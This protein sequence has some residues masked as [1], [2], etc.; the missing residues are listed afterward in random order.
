MIASE[1]I[2]SFVEL[3]DMKNIR[4]HAPTSAIFL[5]GGQTDIKA[6]KPVSLRDAF[7]RINHGVPFSKFEYILA[8]DVNIFS[9]GS[10]YKDFLRLEA[11]IAQISELIMLFSESFGSAAELGAF[12]M[13]DE[14]AMRLMVVID[15]Y[16]YGRDSFIKHGPLLAL[17][18]DYGE[19]SV[20]VL[21]RNGL[22]IEN[23]F[24]VSQIDLVEFSKRLSEAI[25]IRLGKVSEPS[26]FDPSRNGHVI[27]FIVGLIQH[28]GALKID[29]IEVILFCLE[30]IRGRDEIH[31]YLRCAEIT[32]WVRKEREGVSDFYVAR[33]LRE[34]MYYKLKPGSP[35]V[36]RDRWRADIMR[37]WEAAE[38]GRYRAIRRT[39]GGGL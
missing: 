37:H 33:S 38:P 28:Y 20:F 39:I 11:D 27:K 8:E 34:A 18:T 7:L 10:H 32:R 36:D 23:I 17:R 13:I 22:N 35:K 6:N 12:S 16:H 9:P 26:T 1:K 15:D 31:N 24:N 14:I 21:N 4:V 19:S 25:V 2:P 30:I 3:V 5:C 29:E